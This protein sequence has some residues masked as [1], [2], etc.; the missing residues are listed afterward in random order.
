MLSTLDDIHNDIIQKH[1][2]IVRDHTTNFLF[3]LALHNDNDAGE[4]APYLSSI[5]KVK[6]KAEG[7]S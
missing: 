6:M 7:S 3:E 4:T 2:W 1:K 5:W